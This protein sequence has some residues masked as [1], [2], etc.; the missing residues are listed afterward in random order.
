MSNIDYVA[1]EIITRT[2]SPISKVITNSLCES[3]G[4]DYSVINDNNDSNW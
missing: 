4:C 3:R 1:S 2:F